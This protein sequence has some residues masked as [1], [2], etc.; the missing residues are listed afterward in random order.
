MFPG[1]AD[2]NTMQIND[3]TLALDN[4]PT[5]TLTAT[6]GTAR[7]CGIAGSPAPV[8]YGLVAPLETAP[9]DLKLTVVLDK[10]GET[11]SDK[12]ELSVTLPRKPGRKATVTS[13]T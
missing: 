2:K 4:S 12:R 7:L 10:K 8:A 9:S 6:A 1:A 13:L 5:L 3:G 11:T